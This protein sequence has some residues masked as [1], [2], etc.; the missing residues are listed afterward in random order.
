MKLSVATIYREFAFHI[1][2]SIARPAAF[3]A[4]LFLSYLPVYG[5]DNVQTNRNGIE[6]QMGNAQVELAP[7]DTGAFRLSVAFDGKS[8]PAPSSFLADVTV[9]SPIAW[10]VARRDG[11][12]GIQTKA[13]QILMNPEN[14]DWTLLNAGNQVLIP[15]HGAA[16]FSQTNA[17]GD[18]LIDITYGLITNQPF[19]VY[20]C[21]NG[22]P[23]L[24]QTQTVTR[25]ANGVAVIPSYWS[26]NGYAVLAVSSNDNL[27]AD[28]HASAA[29][30]GT[31]TWRFTGNTADLYLMPAANLRAA[32]EA[33]SA[34]TGRAPV[35]P[36]W[37]FGYLQSRWG[38]KDRAYIEDTLKQFKNRK[39][40]VDAFIYDFEWYT[41]TPDYE[42]PPE[43]V[44]GFSDFDWNANLF[45]EPARQIK[46]YKDEGVHFVGIRKPRLGNSA[47]L[48]MIR[49]KGW[50]LRG[51]GTKRESNFQSRDVDFANP[52]F[53]TWYVSQSTNL[54]AKGVDGWWNDE[55]EGAYTTYYYWNLA[56]ARALALVQPNHRLWT[57]NRAFS[58]GVQRLGAAAWTGDIRSTWK[59]LQE[60]PPSLLNWSLAGMP[61]SACDI[62]GYDGEEPSPEMLSR[63]MEAGVFFPIMRSHSALSRTP[64]FPWLF[65]PV[66][67]RAIQKAIDLRYRLIPYYYSLAHKAF[68]TGIPI[69]RPLAM[70]FPGDSQAANLSDQWMMGSSLMAA[71]LLQPGGR[72]SVY[73]PIGTW[74]VFGTNATVAGGQTIEVAAGLD[75]IPVFV[76]AGS[77]LPLGPVVQHTSE[78]PGGPLEL[79][80]YPG[81]DATFTLAEDDGKTTGYVHGQERRIVFKW[82]D[83]HGR[84]SWKISGAYHGPNCFKKV[85]VVYFGAKGRQQV[86]KLLSLS[87]SFSMPGHP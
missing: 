84:L 23:S 49:S 61:Y 36:L 9:S 29:G 16:G 42:V 4:A 55:G 80:I 57:L 11:L 63:W 70:E 62:G 85:R 78:L 13:G 66:V 86:E 46:T 22:N 65:G 15:L 1:Y 75:D 41:T 53:R 2:R 38:W 26:P 73:L 87:G 48:A 77:I 21:G 14:G 67:E 56:E 19:G 45:P 54:L 24:L 12:V 43:G 59:A 76:K 17:A 30:G 44:P 10:E 34:L 50:D 83:A 27:P 60:T 6:I 32:S 58:P 68:E 51:K 79:Q 81:R 25:V 31:V 33:C 64:R 52:D 8:S 69:M 18:P 28:W 35:P 7:V 39:I 47:T 5:Q 20:G 74:Y 71:P 72:R 3:L 37:A 82:N 40:P